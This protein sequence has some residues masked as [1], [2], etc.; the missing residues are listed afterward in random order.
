MSRNSWSV[1]WRKHF[2]DNIR[3]KVTDCPGHPGTGQGISL[4]LLAKHC[5]MSRSRDVT[6]HPECVDDVL[7]RG[8]VS[9]QVIDDLVHL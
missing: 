9:R 3:A 6:H 4:P 1:F 2:I 5:N 8:L 7:G